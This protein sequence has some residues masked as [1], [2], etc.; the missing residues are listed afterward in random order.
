MQRTRLL[1]I[2]PDPAARAM[3]SSMLRSAAYEVIEATSDRSALRMLEEP[4]GLVVNGVGPDDPDALELLS[5]IRRRHR[6]IPVVL[7]FTAPH[8]GCS[9][10]AIRMG[11]DAV[12][13]F[14]LP[15]HQLRAAVAQAL[16]S[17][18]PTPWTDG[19]SEPVGRSSSG[20][21][22]EGSP[23]GP[24]G[25]ERDETEPEQPL[26]AA[27]PGPCTRT[28]HTRAA[29]ERIEPR[30]REAATECHLAAA[31]EDLPEND[32]RSLTAGRA[33]PQISR[34]STTGT[35]PTMAEF[36][37]DSAHCHGDVFARGADRSAGYGQVAPQSSRS[38]TGPIGEVTP[39]AVPVRAGA[40]PR[41]LRE[42]LEGPEREIIERALEA[43]GGSRQETARALDIN[44]TTLWKKMKKYGLLDEFTRP[45]M[46]S[47]C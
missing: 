14:P 46:L 45:Q 32:A 29:N 11:A 37:N 24:V 5:Y 21:A 41:P 31:V 35:F 22:V 38:D 18:R 4:P 16:E 42:A 6:N 26:G 12:L 9:S 44:R 25:P 17:G 13:R 39:T 2:H 15:A 40:L 34:G 8:L 20:S 33:K 10:R 19:A 27:S 23:G 43:F 47:G 3:L 36:G 28:G 30:T 1:I 7:L